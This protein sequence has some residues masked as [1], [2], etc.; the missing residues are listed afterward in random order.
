MYTLKARYLKWTCNYTD[1]L[2]LLISVY[3]II[4]HSVI[5][6]RFA[7]PSVCVGYSNKAQ[8]KTQIILLISH[9]ERFY[10]NWIFS[11]IL[12][13]CSVIIFTKMYGLVGK[14]LV[15]SVHNANCLAPFT[16]RNT[17]SP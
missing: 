12:L 17:K 14:I 15:L 8:V 2:N 1:E 4:M 7:F 5:L 16:H 10:Q 11:W 9:F 6:L 3:P 13:K